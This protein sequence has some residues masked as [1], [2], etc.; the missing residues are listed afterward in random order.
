MRATN[1]QCIIPRED[2]E[3]LM[4]DPIDDCHFSSFSSLSSI[5]F[6]SQEISALN[7]DHNHDHELDDGL[8]SLNQTHWSQNKAVVDPEQIQLT[9]STK[10]D[11]F[12]LK[13]ADGST[14]LLDDDDSDWE[15]RQKLEAYT[16]SPKTEMPS[17]F[18]KYYSI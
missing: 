9:N 8:R 13:M 2:K 1:V 16:I 5:D 18:E 7:D 12:P 6:E 14:W 17:L 15:V 10:K 11:A 4:D 3:T